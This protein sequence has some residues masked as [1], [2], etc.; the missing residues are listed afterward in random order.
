MKSVDS[1]VKALQ[2]WFR[3]GD[4]FCPGTTV[5]ITSYGDMSISLWSDMPDRI[6]TS[7]SE[8][9]GQLHTKCPA[10]I[11]SQCI[12]QAK[13]RWLLLLTSEGVLGWTSMVNSL[14]LLSND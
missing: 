5:Y 1:K 14:R 7:Q 2:G 10:I 8:I 11:I 9:A 12:S 6:S 13:T 3:T 4:L